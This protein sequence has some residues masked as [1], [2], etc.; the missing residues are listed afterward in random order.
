[1]WTLNNYTDEEEAALRALPCRALLYGYE[2]G[3]QET[4][5][6][7]G[8]TIFTTMKSV[9]QVIK[10]LPRRCAKIQIIDNLPSALAY[11]KKGDQSKEEWTELGVEGPNYGSAVSFHEQGDFPMTK[12]EQGLKGP[13][14]W[15]K[16]LVSLKNQDLDSVPSHVQIMCHGACIRIMSEARVCPE[17]MSGELP[18]LWL[19]GDAGTGKTKWAFDMYPELFEK[20][21]DTKWWDGYQDQEVVL[22]DDFDKYH[23]RE[24]YH[25][26][27]W[28]DRYPFNAEI[29]GSS[30]KIRPQL[31][32]VTSN[33]RPDEIWTDDKTL[34]P[35]S[36]RF[37]IVDTNI[38]QWQEALAMDRYL[39]KKVQSVPAVPKLSE[40][41]YES[42]YQRKKY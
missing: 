9:G 22:I 12:S 39:V 4:P 26:K 16:I 1:M 10:M 33:Y 20:A 17:I 23:I 40:E 38:Q 24:G 28:G 5:H 8:V 13:E 3:K 11:C 31:L 14:Y 2:V 27:K 18:H 37:K 19:Y 6:L 25:L 36:R 34:G 7:Q 21:A 30:A 41:L 42:G 32:I 29:K 35:I 15:D